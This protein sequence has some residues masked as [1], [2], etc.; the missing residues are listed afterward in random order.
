MRA[1]Q[2]V[3]AMPKIYGR[4]Q[5][6]E[7]VTASDCPDLTDEEAARVEQLFDPGYG[8]ARPGETEKVTVR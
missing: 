1:P 6:E 4:E 3:S 5:F 7:F 2:W 8:V